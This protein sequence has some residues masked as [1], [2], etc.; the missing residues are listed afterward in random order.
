MNSYF[1]AWLQAWVFCCAGFCSANAISVWIAVFINWILGIP[2]ANHSRS[3]FCSAI[4]APPAFYIHC[5]PENLSLPPAPRSLDPRR[6]TSGQIKIPPLCHGVL[7][8]VSS[9]FIETSCNPNQSQLTSSLFL[10]LLV[11]TFWVKY[12]LAL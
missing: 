9:S 3:Q 12:L 11:N 7:T 4:P 10:T 6:I 2:P 1:Q 5:P 8:L